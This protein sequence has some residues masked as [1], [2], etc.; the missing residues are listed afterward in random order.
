MQLIFISIYYFLIIHFILTWKSNQWVAGKFF[1]V[2]SDICSVIQHIS[3]GLFLCVC[4]CLKYLC[5][6]V[7][8]SMVKVWNNLKLFPLTLESLQFSYVL[9]SVKLKVLTMVF[10]NC[11]INSTSFLAYY[12][13]HYHSTIVLSLLWNVHLYPLVHSLLVSYGYLAYCLPSFWIL[14]LLYPH[15]CLILSTDIN[16][17]VLIAENYY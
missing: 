16:T 14:T 9:L 10:M 5:V 11:S 13:A 7:L 3:H 17:E 6:W 8:P 1:Y 12:Y 2:L 15:A 4:M